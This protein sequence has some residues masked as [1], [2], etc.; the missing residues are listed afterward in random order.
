M[1][2]N[3]G[4][5]KQDELGLDVLVDGEMYRGDMVAYFAER[6]EGFKIGAARA[7][8]RQPLLP[9]ASHRGEGR[10]PKP[11]TV[12]RLFE[13]TQSLTR[14]PVKGMLTGAVHAAGLVIQ[15]G[16]SDAPRRGARARR[17]RPRRGERSRAR[18]REVHPDRRAGDPR[19]PEEIEIAIEAMGIVTAGLSAKT[20]SH[21]C[22]G[23]FENIYPRMLNLAVDNFDLEISN[24]RLDMLRLFSKTVYERH[25]LWRN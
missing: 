6:L 8:V 7:L 11:M 9:Q 15:R 17:D 25:Q 23:D 16:V 12:E 19:A 4:F 18:R 1:P 24:S 2:L 3:F 13:C 5:E 21:I 10:R 20:I 14:K 22:Y